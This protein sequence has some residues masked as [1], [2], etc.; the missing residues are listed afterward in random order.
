[1][2]KIFLHNPLAL[3]IPFL[4]I[5]IF[6]NG[7]INCSAIALS[8]PPARVKSVEP[9][10]LTSLIDGTKTSLHRISNGF[11]NIVPHVKEAMRIRKLMKTM[12]LAELSYTEFRK[13][14]IAT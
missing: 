1:M 5:N 14:E 9:N 13:L 11:R 8:A 4:Y 10:P 3:I 6:L 12:G 7:K 2:L